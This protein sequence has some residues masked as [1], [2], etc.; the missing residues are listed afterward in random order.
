MD[1]NWTVLPTHIPEE[2]RRPYTFAMSNEMYPGLAWDYYKTTSKA[3]PTLK[4]IA[5][6]WGTEAHENWYLLHYDPKGQWFLVHVCAYTAEVETYDAITLIF[7]KNG[8][9]QRAELEEELAAEMEQIAL[10]KL[11]KKFGTLLRIKECDINMT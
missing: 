7:R 10:E 2:R 4:T 11:G 6:M 8:Q 5:P 3:K 1:F 9:H